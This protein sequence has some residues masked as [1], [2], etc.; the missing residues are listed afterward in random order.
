MAVVAEWQKWLQSRGYLRVNMRGI[1]D[2]GDEENNAATGVINDKR[3]TS[4]FSNTSNTPINRSIWGFISKLQVGLKGKPWTHTGIAAAASLLLLL[5]L[6]QIAILLTGP[7]AEIRQVIQE[8][9]SVSSPTFNCSELHLK[10][11]K[12]VVERQQYHTFPSHDP[13]PRN[14]CQSKFQQHCYRKNSGPEHFPPPKFLSLL[15]DYE[16]YHEK[17]TKGYDLSALGITGDTPEGCK[18]LV[19]KSMDGMGNQLLSLICAFVYSLLTNRVMLIATDS[20]VDHFICNPFPL[21]SWLLPKEFPELQLRTGAKRVY[22]YLDETLATIQRNR[23]CNTIPLDDLPS[24]ISNAPKHL[25]AYI[26]CCDAKRDHQFFCPTAQKLFS[27]VNWFFYLSHE[28]TIPGFYLIPEFREKLN[29]WFPHHDV[30]MHAS[31]Y[32]L[33]PENALWA[34]ISQFYKA[35][36]DGVDKQIGI[37][38]RSWRGDYIPS[39]SK[40]IL[41]CA[42]DQKLLPKPLEDQGIIRNQTM[43][44]ALKHERHPDISV[45]VTSLRAEYR[46]NLALEYANHPNEDGSDVDVMAASNEGWQKTGDSDHDAKAIMDIW[47]LSF[48]H[49]LVITPFSTFGSTASGLAGIVPLLFINYGQDKVLEPACGRTNAGGPCFIVYPNNQPCDLDPPRASIFDSTTKVPEVRF[50][51]FNPGLG[52]VTA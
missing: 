24:F 43:E 5:L 18:Y 46:D 45:L 11:E 25:H 19:W 3:T 10:G 28:Y 15:R 13:S 26:I 47:L 52:I 31:R 23:S 40:Q 30:F 34:R 48:A 21:S 2:I 42:V 32:L 7:D 9:R 22:T 6:Y 50:C 20:H 33:N 49:D 36:M 16:A 1:N 27:G 38:P 14:T 8:M 41:R 17:C 12:Q 29:D 37:Q 35:H 44:V 4:P 39:I 51:N